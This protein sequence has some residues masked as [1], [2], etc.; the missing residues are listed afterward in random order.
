M[1]FCLGNRP[2]CAEKRVALVIGNSS[3]QGTAPLPNPKNDAADMSAALRA[4]GFET[5]VATDLDKR[6]MDEAF[7]RFAR[8]ARDADAALFFYAGHGTQR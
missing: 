4:V 1:L 2:G 7:R 8:L 6:G 3:Y 5:I